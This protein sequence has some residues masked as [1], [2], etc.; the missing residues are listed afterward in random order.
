[1]SGFGKHTK[2]YGKEKSM[3]DRSKFATGG[4]SAPKPLRSYHVS[5][6]AP[7]ESLKP[8]GT[9]KLPRKIKGELNMLK[10]GGDVV[11]KKFGHEGAINKKKAQVTEVFTAKKGGSAKPGLWA[12][13]N[14][15]KKLGIS[16]PK[17][18]STISA[19]AYANMKA[20]FPKK[21]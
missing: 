13:I 1:M 10:D 16:R 15:R 9:L 6:K 7:S 14:R 2:G 5:V 8:I 17:S 21:K 18:K 4:F 11:K 20:G 12:N 3:D 19:K